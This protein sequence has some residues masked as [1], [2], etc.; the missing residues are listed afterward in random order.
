MSAP[1]AVVL[2][3]PRARHL[4]SHPRLLEHL[5]EDLGELAEVRV[6]DGLDALEAT[7]AELVD[8]RPALIGLLG[9]DGTLSRALTALIRAHGDVPLPPVALLGGGTM[10]TI[11]RSVGAAGH[12]RRLSSHLRAHLAG[13]VALHP[14]TRHL[15]EVDGDRL[16]FL[17]GNGL[18]ARYI[19][20]YEEG[21]PGPARAAWVLLHAV[22]SAVVGGRFARRLTAPFHAELR[23]DGE[24]LRE[25]EWLVAAAGSIDQVGLGFKPFIGAVANPGTPHALGIGC[26]PFALAFQLHRPLRGVPLDHPDIVER[27]GLELVVHGPPDQP[28]NLDGDLGRT[29]PVTHVRVGPAVTFLVPRAPRPVTSAVRRALPG[30]SRQEDVVADI[31]GVKPTLG[32]GT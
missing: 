12:P 17:F 18:F 30:P 5:R 26:S 28:Y 20:A 16:G 9:G 8:R 4:R 32:P 25:G 11:A 15:L 13:E 10:N 19:E 1:S 27:V 6:P 3:N 31:E 29:G 23:V 21:S 24:V 7:A 14:V 22:G 2:A